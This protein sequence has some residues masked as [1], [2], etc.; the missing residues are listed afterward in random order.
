[1]Y[2]TRGVL[3]G[4]FTSSSA[5]RLSSNALQNIIRALLTVSIRFDF[6]SSNI[7]IT[8]PI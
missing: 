5:P 6:N 8:H 1:M 4:D 3:L 7:L 2:F